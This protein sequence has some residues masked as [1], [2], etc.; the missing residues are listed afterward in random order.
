MVDRC[1]PCCGDTFWGGL[2]P[3]PFVFSLD[4]FTCLAPRLD[5][6][7]A[8]VTAQEPPHI[9]LLVAAGQRARLIV[10]ACR[11]NALLDRSLWIFLSWPPSPHHSVEL[12]GHHLRAAFREA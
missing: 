3:G 10:H 5:G 9:S 12:L 4:H 6:S 8:D 1:E 11:S 2:N 7:E